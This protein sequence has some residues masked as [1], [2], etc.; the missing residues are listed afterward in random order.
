MHGTRIA[1]DQQCTLWTHLAH[2]SCTN[3][4][5]KTHDANIPQHCTQ[6]AWIIGIAGENSS[7]QP[8]A[9]RETAV[10]IVVCRPEFWGN[11][12]S[13]VSTVESPA[14]LWQLTA[15]FVEPLPNQVFPCLN[16]SCPYVMYTKKKQNPP[17]EW[18]QK[19]LLFL[20]HLIFATHYIRGHIECESAVCLWV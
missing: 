5:M 10:N 15:I 14:I 17:Q 6:S 18:E 9:S 16:H 7:A 1:S 12:V 19:P 3:P 8:N 11:I 2:L 20:L 13:R 4:K